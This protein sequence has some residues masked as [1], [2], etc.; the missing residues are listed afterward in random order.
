MIA[1]IFFRPSFPAIL[2][3]PINAGA[4]TMRAG[5]VIVPAVSVFTA[6]PAES[7]VENCFSCYE[8][9]VAV[10]AAESL[11]TPANGGKS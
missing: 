8:A 9:T 2:R 4:F 1:N 7:L 6:K 10:K 5:L 11:G 3:S